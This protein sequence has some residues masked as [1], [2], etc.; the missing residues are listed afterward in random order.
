MPKLDALPVELL[1]HVALFAN[2]FNYGSYNL[3]EL[4]ALRDELGERVRQLR[5]QL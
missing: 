3:K 2:K 4:L 5:T 1:A